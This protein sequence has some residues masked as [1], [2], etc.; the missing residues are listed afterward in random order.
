MLSLSRGFKVQL[1]LQLTSLFAGTIVTFYGGEVKNKVEMF[2]AFGSDFAP[3]GPN[4]ASYSPRHTIDCGKDIQFSP[5]A[6]YA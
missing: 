2:A 6:L 3:A 5:S 1:A 4:V